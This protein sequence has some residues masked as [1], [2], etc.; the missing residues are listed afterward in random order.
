[1]KD[2]EIDAPRYDQKVAVTVASDGP[3]DVFVYLKKDRETVLAAIAKNPTQAPVLAFKEAA[4]NDT[5]E[6]TFPAKET[7]V[8]TVAAGLKPVSVKLKVVAK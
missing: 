2:T 5:L 3:V 4:R 6:V 7:A 1:M 8:I